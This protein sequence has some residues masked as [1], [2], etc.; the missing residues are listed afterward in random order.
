MTD[1]ATDYLL[2]RGNFMQASA[3]DELLQRVAAKP[4]SSGAAAAPATNPTQDAEGGDGRDSG[5]MRAAKDLGGGVIETPRAIVK[6]VRDAYQSA[7]NMGGEFGGWVEKTLDLPTFT[8]DGGGVHM[9]TGE[10]RDALRAKQGPTGA[11]PQLPDLEPPKTVTGGV[12]KGVAQFLTG[13]KGAGKVAQ[14]LKVPEM[15]G[16]A[17]YALAAAKGAAANFAFFDPHQERLSNLI[18]EYPALANPVNEYLAAKPD[19]GAAEGRFKNA[20][21]G[22][23]LGVLTDGFFKGVRL[24]REVNFAKAKGTAAEEALAAAG[25]APREMPANAFQGIGDA[26]DDTLVKLRPKATAPELKAGPDMTPEQLAAAK[27]AAKP[28]SEVFINF[29]RIDSPEDIQKVLGKIAS[30]NQKGIDAARRGKQT[31]EEIKLNANERDA[32]KDLMER[33]EG[34]PMNA[35]ATLAA[36]Q[37]WVSSAHKL[38]EVAEHAAGNPSEANLFA[39]RKMLA[40]HDAIQTQVIAA[41]TETARALSQWRIPA[42]GNAE[43]MRDVLARLEQTGGGEVAR[44]LADRISKLGR[45]GATKELTKVVEKTA[46]AKTRDAVVEGWINGLLSNP[47]TH[48]ANTV[49]N[50]ATGFLR[51]LERGVGERISR[52][53]GHNDGIA[54]GEAMAQYSGLVQG[55]RD[56]F[57]YYGKRANLLLN[58]DVE[59]FKAAR[60]ES[61]AVKSGLA[62]A[63]KV[64]HPPA[65][66]SEALKISNEG[67]LGRT[68]DMAGQLVRG[69]STA[70][71]AEDEFFKTIGYRME[72]NAQA[73]RQAASEVHAGKIKP[74]AFKQRVAE[75]VENP[76]EN[77]RMA[78]ADSALYQTFT[79]SPGKIAGSL[80]RLTSEYPALKVIMPFVKTPANILKFT[81]ERTPLAPLMSKFRADIQA[82]GAR[83]DLALAQVSTGTTAMLAFADLAMQGKISGRGP[84]D[85]SERAALTRE[86]WKPYSIRV[87]DRWY[88]YNRLDPVGSLIGLSADSVEAQRNAQAESVDDN[89]AER[90]AVGTAIA[91]AGNLT[92]KTYLSGLSDVFEALSDPQRYGEGT[93]QRMVG[94]VVPA[95]VAAANR[96]DDPY[97]REVNSMIDAMRSRTPGLS[98]KLPPKRDLWGEPVK[99]GTGM[100]S[101][102]DLFSPVQ[103]ANPT[104]EPIDQE[105]LRL[106]AHVTMPAKKTNFDGVTVDL[107]QYPAAYSRYLELAGNE[108]K[109]PAWKMGAKDLLNKI[110]GGEHALSPVYRLRSD[111][112]EG[113]KDFFIRDIVSQ[114][115]EMARAQLIKEY[116]DLAA[117]VR[118][119]KAHAR[120]LKLPVTQ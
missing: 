42:G 39:F 113:G 47:A 106:G 55:A 116:P 93:V 30:E 32:W 82:G 65:I 66:S 96:I 37:L 9:Q 92:N 33:R 78:S 89:D 85:N 94:S 48:A 52:S 100:G 8:I 44:E 38:T 3:A 22:L 35:E 105:I 74:D 57:R 56:M 25:N 43:R 77:I 49:S 19:D 80:S 110:V 6:G 45:A 61:P 68:V 102:V 46:Y 69:P 108:L 2:H 79:N 88:P 7:M 117:D 90:I 54:T 103:S 50:T 1:L 101:A 58:E 11:I 16:K 27:K 21:E 18:Q 83:R 72:L 75:I 60:A 107:S 67:F 98:D 59:G 115:R 36:R 17:G 114:Y 87:G 40:V 64:E 71:G 120:A 99:Y 91:F 23:G 119:K 5:A 31:F 51:M 53:L 118:E 112:P 24:L 28:E 104:P 73:V 20:L 10:E 97:V 70:L 26:A 29:A 12:V 81:F 62:D 95:G 13:M 41:R 76:P 4:K 111:G 15:A 14:S 86:G 63:T 84:T 109:H 34:D